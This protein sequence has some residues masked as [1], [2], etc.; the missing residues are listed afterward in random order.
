[1]DDGPTK[2]IPAYATADEGTR[3]QPTVDADGA[4][5]TRQNWGET[6]ARVLNFPTRPYD[7]AKPD[8]LRI[9]PHSGVIPFD[10]ELRDG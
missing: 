2:R 10:W 3:D 4:C 8:K 9:D 5:G 7:P 1:V 6:D